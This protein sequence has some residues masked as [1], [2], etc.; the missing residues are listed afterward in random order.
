M[1]TSKKKYKLKTIRLPKVLQR[2]QLLR[3]VTCDGPI[4]CIVLKFVNGYRID[5]ATFDPANCYQ[6]VTPKDKATKCKKQK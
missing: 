5:I 4:P 6:I 1:T 2:C 3:I